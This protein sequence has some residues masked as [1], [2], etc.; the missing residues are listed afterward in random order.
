MPDLCR[1]DDYII[2]RCTV[3][4][5]YQTR[6]SGYMITKGKLE[7]YHN[8][9]ITPYSR[10]LGLK[11]I[12]YPVLAYARLETSTNLTILTPTNVRNC[13]HTDCGKYVGRL[14]KL[15]YFTLYV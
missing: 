9:Y 4:I 2:V 3:F 6:F 1:S 10:V 7:A 14:Q 5:S 11:R 12:Y 13:A 15:S 8:T